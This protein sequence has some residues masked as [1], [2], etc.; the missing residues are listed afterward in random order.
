MAQIGRS[1]LWTRIRG[2]IDGMRHP[3]AFPAFPRRTPLVIGHRGAP[4]E[5]AENTV[6]SFERA[7]ALGADTVETDLCVTSDGVVVV[8]HD[9]NPDHAIGLARQAGREKQAFVPDVPAIGHPTRTRISRLTYPSFQRH[10]GYHKRGPL[11]RDLLRGSNPPEL[12]AITF[13]ALI[14]WLE[15]EDRVRHVFLD[16]KLDSEDMQV[17]G[18]LYR[19][20]CDAATRLPHVTLHVLSCVEEICSALLAREPHRGVRIY[21]DCELP[22]VLASAE[23]LGTPHVSL[24]CGKRWWA[25]FR[26]EVAE[27]VA[28]RDAGRISTVIVWTVNSERRLE[29]LIRFGV[30]GIITD[31]SDMLRA[32]L[33]AAAPPAALPQPSRR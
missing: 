19:A 26:R 15:R 12:P 28:A 31:R 29:E 18:V 13:E 20:L 7:V 22:G 25:D 14:R 16:I 17:V 27:V 4:L 6:E 33:R 9:A 2:A 21:V 10:F 23:R 3:P 11:L 8:W 1:G 24:G 5:R 32:M 30:D